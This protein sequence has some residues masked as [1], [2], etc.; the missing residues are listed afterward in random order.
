MSRVPFLGI[1][2]GVTALCLTG[3]VKPP[4][5]HPAFTPPVAGTQNRPAA[6]V[7]A[8]NTEANDG[9]FPLQDIPAAGNEIPPATDEPLEAATNEELAA[10]NL[11]DSLAP[12]GEP[13]APDVTAPDDTFPKEPTPA[14]TA[15]P[16]V[17]EAAAGKDEKAVGPR[18][19]SAPKPRGDVRS[20][21]SRVAVRPKASTKAASVRKRSPSQ[22]YT[23]R[24]HV[25]ASE[26]PLS[27]KRVAQYSDRELER[28]SR[29]IKA[30]RGKP[31]SDPKWEREFR[32]E[33]WY[34]ADPDYSDA[35]LSP[36]EREN[37]RR[38]RQ[39]E[40]ARRK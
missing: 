21:R 19:A 37:L 10:A 18:V 34:Q 33:G 11:M 36:T 27:R 6:P 32:N 9:A 40:E 26:Q 13:P 1:L 22:P 31:F 7:A 14:A 25:K 38:I 35:H 15:K 8:A 3:C 12:E 29:E 30:R 4:A 16:T 39:Q 23:A 17:G 5:D 24:N 28:V 20:T 2:V